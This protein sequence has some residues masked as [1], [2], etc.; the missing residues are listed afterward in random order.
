MPDFAYS[1]STS[2]GPVTLT[3][4]SPPGTD[5]G[6]GATS[7]VFDAIVCS[8]EANA[9]T[10][11]TSHRFVVSADG[12]EKLSYAFQCG[13][14]SGASVT[15]AGGFAG[16]FIA[17]FP[18]GLGPRVSGSNITIG[19]VSDGGAAVAKSFINISYHFA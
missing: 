9:T 4:P 5:G 19:V 3:L 8:S 18:G 16:G 10:A 13:S 6:F 2:A 14:A 15:T 7:L 1:N 12:V 17:T 11:P